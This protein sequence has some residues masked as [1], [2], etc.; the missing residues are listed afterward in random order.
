MSTPAEMA[1]TVGCAASTK[2]GVLDE[3]DPWWPTFSRSTRGTAPRATIAVSTGASA[4]PVSSALKAP[5]RSTATTEPLLMSASGRGAA[6]SA[7][8]G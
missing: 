1:A 4:S 7:S 2:A 3:C 8:E 5:W 6:A